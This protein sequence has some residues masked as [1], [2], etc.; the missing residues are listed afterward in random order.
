MVETLRYEPEG[1]GFDFRICHW[2]FFNWLNPSGRTVVLGSTQ[3]LIEIIIR[4]I[5]WGVN[6]AGE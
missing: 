6:A 5:S 2:D 4:D 3:L 1:R